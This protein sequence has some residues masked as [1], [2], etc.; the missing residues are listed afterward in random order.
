M[1][2]VARFRFLGAERLGI[3][4][5]DHYVDPTRATTALLRE[6]GV[7]NAAALAHA[8]VPND[9]VGIL[10]GGP[11]TLAALGDAVAYAEALEPDLARAEGL[12][13]P[14]SETRTL[15]PIPRP[16]K[17]ICVARNY[18]EHAKEAGLPIPEIPILFPRFANTQL[19]DGEAILIPAASDQV[20]WEGELAVVIGSGGRHIPEREALEHVGGYTI[21]NDV[22][23]RDFQFRVTQYTAGKNFQASGPIGPTISLTDEGLDPHGLEITTSVNGVVKQRGNTNAM[24]FDIPTLIAHI[25]EFIELEPGD[26]IPTGTPSGVGFKRTPAEFLRHGDRVEVAIA[27]LGVLSNPVEN[28][29]QHG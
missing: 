20:D 23:V 11:D 24:I 22:S 2:R 1:T 28:E 17:I 12:I 21:F 6:R 15:V 3:L 18:G 7:W 19:A 27:G 9:T 8:R 13:V 25:S 26:I 4:R 16:P 5:G 14:V 29:V 10:A